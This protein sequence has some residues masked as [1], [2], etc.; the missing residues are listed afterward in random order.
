[1]RKCQQEV[2]Q[3]DRACLGD[4]EGNDLRVIV[5]GGDKVRGQ[6]V[7][8]HAYQLGKTYR[9]D[10]A[11]MCSLFGAVVF[12]CAEVLADESGERQR[13]AGDRQKAE[14]LD[15]GIG[16]AAGDCHFSEAVDIGLYDYVR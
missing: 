2:E 3:C 6:D 13:K 10:D 15:L 5:K 4:A 8:A 16:A 7:D 11:E 9:A 14:A 1:M 12:F